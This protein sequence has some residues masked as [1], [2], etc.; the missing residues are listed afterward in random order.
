MIKSVWKFINIIAISHKRGMEQ[1][2]IID[3]FWTYQLLTNLSTKRVISKHDRYCLIRNFSFVS[4]NIF[5][6]PR[7]RRQLNSISQRNLKKRRF[8][9]FTNFIV[10][11]FFF[12]FE[13]LTWEGHLFL[14]PRFL[15][16]LLFSGNVVFFSIYLLRLSGASS[17][18]T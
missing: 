13:G 14:Y 9:P 17:S 4:N 18:C 5:H 11:L 7:V 3:T 6:I 15:F 10:M 12:S 1:A 16:L 8:H 2:K